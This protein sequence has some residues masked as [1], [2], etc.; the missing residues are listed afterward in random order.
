MT[1]R[2]GGLDVSSK[3]LRSGTISLA[4]N[5]IMAVSGVAP[6]Y[7]LA[8]TL[9]AVVA[10]A[11]AKTP[12]LL[13][14]G[15]VPMLLIAF[16]FRELANET[17][18]C[19]STFT[20]VTRAFGPWV[21]W[22][23]GWALV[24]AS[25]VTIGN[26]AQLAATY[27][28]DAVH[29]NKLQLGKLHVDSIAQ[30]LPIQITLGGV[31]VVVL[32]MLCLWG[33]DATERT[34]AVLLI[35]QF[36]ML[37]LF[38]GVALVKV[39]THHAGPQA[40]VPQWGWLSPTGLSASA[41]AS[42]S[43]LCVFLYWGWDTSLSVSEETKNPRENPGKAG[44]LATILTLCT[45]VLVSIAIQAFAGFGT[46]GIGLNNRANTNG[47]LRILRRPGRRQRPG[48]GTAVGDQFVV[49]SVVGEL[50]GA[51]SAHHPGHGGIQGLAAAVWAGAPPIPHPM[52]RHHCDRRG[53]VLD[54]CLDDSVE[55][56]LAIGHGVITWTGHRL[57]L[58]N[59][60]V[61]LC[62]DLPAYI[63]ALSSPVLVERRPPACRRGGDEL[64]VHQERRRHVRT[65]LRHD[66]HRSGRG[67]VHH[68]DGPPADRH[69]ACCAVHH[70]WA[71]L[72]RRQDPERVY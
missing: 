24:I 60:R 22:L 20:W 42:G 71:R 6:A 41:I 12:A 14:I 47:A 40:V 35:V 57:L 52:V 33:I 69:P 56:E 34:Q 16:A 36:A 21:G 10:V 18:D 49:V 50:P 15:F 38:S 65:E 55:P 7:S 62:V 19:G 8:A 48:R 27:F 58:R 3:G 31:A 39:Y 5:V 32:I 1:V 13:V 68:G 45:Y 4:G 46:N 70:H 63:A 25:M 28:L 51:D 11:G 61:C 29:L 30:S 54:L 9:A 59:D 64:G 17:P 44:V 26:S 66:A 53:R 23:A 37:F 67:R 2:T 72:L 43:I